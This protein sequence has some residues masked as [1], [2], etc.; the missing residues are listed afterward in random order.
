MRQ[1]FE[2]RVQK[3]VQGIVSQARQHGVKEGIGAGRSQLEG[4]A[5]RSQL[6]ELLGI[7]DAFV[8]FLT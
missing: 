6:D 3:V 1:W 2:E 4:L 7:C 5:S 8:D